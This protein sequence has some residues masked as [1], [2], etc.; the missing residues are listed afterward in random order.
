MVNYF[1]FIL[2]LYLCVQRFREMP[3]L[4]IPKLLDVNFTFQIDV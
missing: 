1:L 4:Y 2:M 3:N